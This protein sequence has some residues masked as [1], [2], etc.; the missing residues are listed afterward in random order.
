MLS[1]VICTQDIDTSQ[2]QQSRP[3][4]GLEAQRVRITEAILNAARPVCPSTFR[5][6][7]K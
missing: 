4:F 3:G 7:L 1:L 6:V 5:E 2:N